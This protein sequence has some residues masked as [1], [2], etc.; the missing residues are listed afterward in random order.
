MPP[1]LLSAFA[2]EVVR[3]I[4]LETPEEMVLVM[5]SARVMLGRDCVG[6]GGRVNDGDDCSDERLERPLI[7]PPSNFGGTLREEFSSF[8]NGDSMRRAM[9]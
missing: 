3:R 6:V 7:D 2:K 8:E 1:R 9:M 5:V 4:V